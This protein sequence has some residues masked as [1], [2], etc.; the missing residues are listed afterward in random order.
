MVFITFLFLFTKSYA[1]PLTEFALEQLDKQ[2]SYSC[3]GPDYFDCSGFVYYCVNETCE[4]KIERTAKEQGYDERYEKIESIEDLQEG[5]L[6]YFNTV[7]D[8]DLCD[9]AA[10]YLGNNEFIH[11][12]SAKRKVIITELKGTYYEG[13]FSWGRRVEYEN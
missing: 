7:R 11:C 10:I 6:L 1:T 8:N 2:Y 4:N 9:H 5:D 13:L 12:S 3:C